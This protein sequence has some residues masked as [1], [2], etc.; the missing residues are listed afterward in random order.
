MSAW[1]DVFGVNV[2]YRDTKNS[3]YSFELFLT[4][5]NRFSQQQIISGI[6]NIL[7]TH[8]ALKGSIR[9]LYYYDAPTPKFWKG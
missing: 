3:Q 1:F 2:T 9:I 5:E 4:V 8:V 7:E 6:I